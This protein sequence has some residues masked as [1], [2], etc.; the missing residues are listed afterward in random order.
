[1]CCPRSTIRTR[2]E[3][4]DEPPL[5]RQRVLDHVRGV[6]GAGWSS[7]G[8]RR[9][10]RRR[11][12]SLKSRRTQRGTTKTH[13]RDTAFGGPQITSNKGFVIAWTGT[14]ADH[15]INVAESR[16]HP[17]HGAT[18]AG[19]AHAHASPADGSARGSGSASPDAWRCAGTPTQSGWSMLQVGRP[20]TGLR[21]HITQAH[22]TSDIGVLVDRTGY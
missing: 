7:T 18:A 4:P 2:S 19:K 9:S 14:G 20:C 13:F 22:D 5:M 10:R 3:R 16:C 15:I 21:R 17:S 12:S 6:V 11:L 1:M 8:E